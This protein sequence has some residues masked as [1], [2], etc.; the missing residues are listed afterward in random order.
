MPVHFS[1]AVPFSFCLLALVAAGS[2][3]RPQL[4]PVRWRHVCGGRQEGSGLHT[5][6]HTRAR[7]R[8]CVF[9]ITLL[10]RILARARAPV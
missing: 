10:T 6:T 4:Q 7:A 8:V 5:H 2:E 9:A 1:F 3:V